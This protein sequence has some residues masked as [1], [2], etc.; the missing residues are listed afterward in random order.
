MFSSTSSL[1]LM[2]TLYC[3]SLTERW[4]TCE[5]YKMATAGQMPPNTLLPDGRHL[6][7]SR[8]PSREGLPVIDSEP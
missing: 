2:K 3:E 1:E 5:R 6:S 4:N 8:I 7:S